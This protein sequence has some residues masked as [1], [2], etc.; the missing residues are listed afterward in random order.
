[1]SPSSGAAHELQGTDH[2]AASKAP[3]DGDAA[4]TGWFPT[5]RGLL[6]SPPEASLPVQ[7]EETIFCSSFS[8]LP[9]LW[10]ELPSGL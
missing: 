1:M 6:R 9:L 10:A 4:D 5:D 2:G 8:A 3:R 7:K